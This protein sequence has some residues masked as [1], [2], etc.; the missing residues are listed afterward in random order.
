M[1][2]CE[3][4]PVKL[5]HEEEIIAAAYGFERTMKAKIQ[6]FEDRSFQKL[7]FADR[8]ARDVE[9][10]GAEIAV[11]RYLG[12]KDFKP[13]NDAFKNFADI[14]FNIEVKWTK[15]KDG[16]LILDERQRENDVAVLV[17]GN[18]PNLYVCGWTPVSLARRPSRRRSDGCYWIGQSDLYPMND[19]LRSSYGNPEA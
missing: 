10:T 16:S 15:W 4:I 3:M 13:D 11:A 19:F 12:L 17:T 6:G 7:N 2:R 18:M 1:L 9:S 14:G 5:T 8:I